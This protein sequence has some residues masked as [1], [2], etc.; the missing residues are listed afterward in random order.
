MTARPAARP[1]ARPAG[2]Y[3]HR[4]TRVRAHPWTGHRED[5]PALCSF[6][7][8]VLEAEDLPGL[9]ACIPLATRN[10]TVYALPGDVVVMNERGE[11]YPI[12]DAEF[13]R[14]YR[15]KEEQPA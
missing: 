7:G 14:S 4:P 2:V 3:V 10:G 13:A 15:L 6:F 11:L 1:P 5:L 12:A 9:G 8:R